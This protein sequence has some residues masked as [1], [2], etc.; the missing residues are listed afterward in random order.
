MGIS[1][2]PQVGMALKGDWKSVA[3][4][5]GEPFVMTSFKMLTLKLL[6]TS[7]AL[8]AQELLLTIPLKY[9]MALDPSSLTMFSA[10]ELNQG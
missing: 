3:V 5:V 10:Q 4:V 8:L 9:Q 7:S 1:G 6:A 2:C